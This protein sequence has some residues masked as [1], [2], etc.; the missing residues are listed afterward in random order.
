MTHRDYCDGRSEVTS[1][2]AH[3]VRRECEACGGAWTLA[4]CLA[5]KADAAQCR[6]IAAVPHGDPRWCLAHAHPWHRTGT[7][8][9]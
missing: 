4:R 8:K 3:E 1:L 5:L 2:N 7:V 9:Q 6:A